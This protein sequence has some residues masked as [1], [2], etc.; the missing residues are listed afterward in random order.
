MTVS[1]SVELI[2]TFPGHTHLPSVNKPIKCILLICLSINISYINHQRLY[3]FA[4]Q[5]VIAP[6]TFTCLCVYNVSELNRKET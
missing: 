6:Y 4:F 1:V 2:M 3:S 5:C